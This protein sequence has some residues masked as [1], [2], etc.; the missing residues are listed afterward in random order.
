MS[1]HGKLEI[2]FRDIDEYDYYF[3]VQYFGDN[4][5]IW[6]LSHMSA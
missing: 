5:E 1:C 4:Y 2:G 6:N 3:S